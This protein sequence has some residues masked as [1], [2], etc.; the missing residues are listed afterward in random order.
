MFM[1]NGKKQ[2]KKHVE[3]LA[4]QRFCE[5]ASLQRRISA[6][7]ELPWD[8]PVDGQWELLRG[9]CCRGWNKAKVLASGCGLLPLCCWLCVP[10]ASGAGARHG[11]VGSVGRELGV[12]SGWH[13]GLS[14]AWWRR[15][16]GESQVH[17]APVLQTLPRRFPQGRGRLLEGWGRRWEHSTR[18]ALVQDTGIFPRSSFCAGRNNCSCR[19]RAA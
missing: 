14:P 13:S 4:G 5:P 7:L 11:T 15:R 17:A 10:S 12:L 8:A 1:G 16:A 9:G 18:S 3:T 2:T 6:S 19:G